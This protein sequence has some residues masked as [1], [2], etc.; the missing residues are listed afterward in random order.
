MKITDVESAWISM[1]LPV[2]RGLSGGPI[3]SSTDAVCRIR[4]DEC[5]HGIGESRGGPLDQICQVIDTA[6]K[7][8]L[9]NQNPL[10]TEYLWQEMYRNL[11]GE[12]VKKPKDW[13]RRTILG[14]IA[15][16]DLALWDIKARSA[17]L[18]ICQLLGG[19]PHPMPAYLSE[20][21]YIEGQTLDGMVRE[22]GEAMEA[23]GFKALKIRI[24]RGEPKDSEARVK[25]IRDGL[26]DEIDLMADVNQAWDVEKSIE[27]CKRLEDYNL[28][29]LEEPIPVRRTSEYDPDRACGEIARTTSIPIASGE[30]HIDLA[31]CRSLVEHGG[32]RYMQFDAIKNGGVTEFLKVAA[33]CHAYD[34][35]MAPHHVAHFHVQ[36]AASVP[37]GFILEA[38]DNAKQHIAWPDLFPGFPEVENGHIPVP[39]KPGWGMEINDELIE[40][41]G[42]KVHWKG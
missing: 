29:W 23:G 10:E 40:K 1:P 39:D 25:A 28:F 6:L 13:S 26:G 36:L 41:N 17:N 12:G 33:F 38:F 8:I 32:I 5:I 18:S 37:N 35:P 34:I 14:A 4:T 20:G 11:L 7:P 15:A 30:N 3:R 9:L 27:T 2:P 16:V 21:F 19:H 24:G 22:A 31:E 42:V